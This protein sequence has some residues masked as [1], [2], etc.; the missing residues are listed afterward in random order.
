MNDLDQMRVERDYFSAELQKARDENDRLEAAAGMAKYW[1]EQYDLVRAH[2]DRVR[3]A[4]DSSGI[5]GG[6]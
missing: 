3:A 6:K 4:L 5:Q 1:R 2:L